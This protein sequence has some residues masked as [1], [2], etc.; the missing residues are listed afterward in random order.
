MIDAD[1][2]II[3]SGY[4]RG[5]RASNIIEKEWVDAADGVAGDD[6]K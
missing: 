1:I 2:E 4:I 6:T 3:L 5:I